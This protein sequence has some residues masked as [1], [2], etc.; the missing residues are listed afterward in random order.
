MLFQKNVMILATEATEES[1]GIDLLLPETSE[2]IAGVLAFL[3]IGFVVWKWVFPQITKTLEARQEAIKAELE[4]AEAAKLEAE[5]LRD[6]YLSQISGA[7]DEANRIVEEARQAG[8][9]VRSDVLARAEQEAA[10]IKE[11]TRADV[12]GERERMASAIQREVATLSLDVAEKVIGQALDRD[13]QR[14]LV[15]R[16]IDDLGQ[17]GG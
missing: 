10:G 5:K 9:S 8:E 17:D 3:I 2:L 7:R 1:E 12:A 11:R 6:D 4:S 16:Y 14:A 13:S 15:D